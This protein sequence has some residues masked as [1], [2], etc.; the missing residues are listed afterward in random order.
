MMAYSNFKNTN[1]E[2]LF[3]WPNLKKFIFIKDVLDLIDRIIILKHIILRFYSKTI[4]K[5]TKSCFSHTSKV[6]KVSK[7]SRL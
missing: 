4:L 7:K 6:F 1:L 3:N 2:N 5:V